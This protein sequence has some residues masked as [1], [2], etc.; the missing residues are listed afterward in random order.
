LIAI[1]PTSRNDRHNFACAERYEFCGI[2][3]LI[4]K[5]VYDDVFKQE[6]TSFSVF[7]TYMAFYESE[8]EA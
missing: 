2:F 6:E 8:N 7:A 1:L 5:A 3:L 4:L